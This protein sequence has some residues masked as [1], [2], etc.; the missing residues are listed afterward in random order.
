MSSVDDGRYVPTRRKFLRLAGMSALTAGAALTAGCSGS[1]PGSP[2]GNPS[3]QEA[4]LSHTPVDVWNNWTGTDQKNIADILQ[5]VNKIQDKVVLKN[6]TVPGDM[7]QKLLAAINARTPPDVA[8]LFG[9]Q[10]AYQLAG[11][12]AI[13]P[14]DEVAPASELQALKKWL[15][16]AMW[17]L[18]T[19]DGKLVFVPLWAQSYGVYVNT[20][21]AQKAGIDPGKPP[22]TL[23]DL[24]AAWLEMTVKKSNGE[25]QIMGGSTSDLNMTMGRFLGQFVSKDGRTITANSENNL[26]AAKWIDDHYAKLGR[27]QVARFNASLQGRS[28]RSGTQD[29]FLA[30]L[31]ASEINGAWEE[32]TIMDYGKNFEYVVWPVPRPAGVSKTGSWTYGDGFVLPQRSK[33]AAAGWQAVRYLSGSTGDQAAYTDLFKVWQCANGPNSEQATKWKGFQEGVIA[34]CP[35][36][37]EVFLKDLF[38]SDQ[39]LFPPKI[40]TSNAYLTQLSDQMGKALVGQISVETALQTTNKL[41]QQDLDRWY[42]Q[43]GHG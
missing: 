7:N 20:K 6:V 35:Q 15:S 9:G 18:G 14:F 42:A 23:E 11:R 31:V 25:I 21:L 32:S 4:Q 30:G 24:A 28:D 3:K 10:N 16:P 27:K 37:Q 26:K 1:G 19:F 17:D 13:V 38:H 12:N 34:K 22:Q 33:S 39:Y 2:G 8:I 36:Y 41:A 43:N 29:P 40:P 5:G